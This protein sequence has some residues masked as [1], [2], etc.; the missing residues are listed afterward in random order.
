MLGIFHDIQ[1]IIALAV[2]ASVAIG[3]ISRHIGKKKKR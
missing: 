2:L 1:K 3:F